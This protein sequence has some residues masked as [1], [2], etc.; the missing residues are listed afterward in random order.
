MTARYSHFSADPVRRAAN[1]IG[2]SLEASMAA[3]R[4]P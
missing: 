4:A 3:D 1:A 2:E